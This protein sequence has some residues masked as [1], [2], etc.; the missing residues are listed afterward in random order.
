[1]E[2][3]VIADEELVISFRLFISALDVTFMLMRDCQF[4]FSLFHSSRKMHFT[5]FP[6]SSTSS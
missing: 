3:T 2:C 5:R 1:M 4:M 6:L